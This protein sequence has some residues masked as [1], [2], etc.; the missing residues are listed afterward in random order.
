MI[1]S[2]Y[3][4]FF[5][6]LADD[7]NDSY[8]RDPSTLAF[9]SRLNSSKRAFVFFPSLQVGPVM[10]DNMPEISSSCT[11]VVWPGVVADGRN[12]KA[13]SALKIPMKLPYHLNLSAVLVFTSLVVVMPG[14]E[15]LS[16]SP[17]L[18]SSLSPELTTIALKSALAHVG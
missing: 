11:R 4:I 5:P 16:L 13:C 6:P 1:A 9:S 7:G 17:G 8:E 12:S 15:I 3:Q 14:R 2:F 18:M 10:N